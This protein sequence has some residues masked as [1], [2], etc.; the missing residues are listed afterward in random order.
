MKKKKL[1]VVDAS[2]ARAAGYSEHPTSSA[3]RQILMDILNICHSVAL[4]PE[5]R[6]EWQQHQ[7][8]FTYKWRAS[9]AAKRK[10]LHDIITTPCVLDLNR[11]DE[12]SRAAIEKDLHLLELALAT[13]KEIITLDTALSIALK[14][15][16]SGMQLH[17][18]IS[19][20][21]RIVDRSRLLQSAPENTAI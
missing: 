11:F 16:S 17:D 14:S 21:D 5:L 18:R 4:N 9:M 3:C 1:L 20:I 2:V 19:W 13:D 6:R 15:Q 8:R 12:K 7:S 10:P